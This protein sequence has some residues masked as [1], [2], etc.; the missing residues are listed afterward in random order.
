MRVT[1]IT[2]LDGTKGKFSANQIA[3]ALDANFD[4]DSSNSSEV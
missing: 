4:D 2:F 3:E 1:N